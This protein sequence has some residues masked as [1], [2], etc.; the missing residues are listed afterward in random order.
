[1][2]ETRLHLDGVGSPIITQV[3]RRSETGMTV[4]QTLPFLKLHTLVHDDDSVA[5]KIESVSVEQGVVGRVLGY[6][7]VILIGTGGTREP[8]KE[9]SSPIE[10]R[11]KLQFQI[12]SEP[13]TP[14]LPREHSREVKSCPYCAEEILEAAVK[15]KHCG[16]DF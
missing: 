3:T 16:S 1:M 11:R 14:R 15:C 2:S 7:D 10:F 12:S 9:I 6:G 4:E 5:S 13:Q 8:L